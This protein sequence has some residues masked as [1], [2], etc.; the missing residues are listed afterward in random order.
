[1]C[2]V[3]GLGGPASAWGSQKVISMPPAEDET[4]VT[5]S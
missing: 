2:D 5:T 4:V 3:T 1:M